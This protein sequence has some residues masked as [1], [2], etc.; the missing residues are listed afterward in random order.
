MFF[1]GRNVEWTTQA[2]EIG[3]LSKNAETVT[4]RKLIE[5]NYF[6]MFR[7]Q[8]LGCSASVSAFV[9]LQWL[10]Q[11]AG[12]RRNSFGRRAPRLR[13]QRLC[14]SF[15]FSAAFVIF[16]FLDLRDVGFKKVPRCGCF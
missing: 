6:G 15:A 12:C 1:C 9:V 3:K 4:S 8:E 11:P 5:R 14:C 10:Q 13:I 16:P 7:G 2:S